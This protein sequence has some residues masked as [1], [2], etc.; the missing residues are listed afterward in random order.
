MFPSRQ[1]RVADESCFSN[2][3]TFQEIFK[4]MLQKSLR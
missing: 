4:D 1:T 3:D 2:C